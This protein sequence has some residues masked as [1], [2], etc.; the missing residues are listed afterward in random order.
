MN[1]TDEL[2]SAF[3]RFSKNLKGPFHLKAIFFDMDGVLF[4][5]MP[6]HAEAWIKVF[7]ENGLDLPEVEPYL[8]E[9][10]TALFTVKN[11]FK[12]YLR[13][14]ATEE[15]AEI[16]REQKHSFMASLPEPDVMEPMPRLLSQIRKMG[17][18]CW[19][20]TGSAQEVLLQRI[21]QAYGNSLERVKTI[22][23]L[24]VT[25]GK[26]H[27]EPYLKALQKSGY[28][29]LESIVVENAPLG[30]L[31]AKAAG[32]FTIAVNTGPLDPKILE[33]AGA[34]VVFSGA[35]EFS[36]KW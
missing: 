20:V 32:L 22:T 33:D 21:E 27:P 12:K 1:K 25:H 4:N 16:I 26:P 34:D 28:S 19:V 24:D 7:K 30:V 9:G 11:M 3:Y 29:I 17:I 35:K 8:N 2:K 6:Q 10:S 15:M 13:Q 23:G 18:D 31:S 36:D 14:E 5:S